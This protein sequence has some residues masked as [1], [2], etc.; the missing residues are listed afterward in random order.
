MNVAENEKKA[1]NHTLSLWPGSDYPLGATYD[2]IGT[3]FSIFSEVAQRVEL[4]L[5]D[6]SGGET[7]LAL[8]E[9]NGFVWHGYLSGLGPGQRYG[10]RVHGPWD[11]AYGHRCCPSKLLL[12]PYAKAIE[13]AV[14]W[15]DALF[16]AKGKNLD[17][18]PDPTDTAGVMPKCVVINPYF[19]WSKERRPNVP[20]HDTIIYEAHVKGFTF[21]H[22]DIPEAIRGTYAGLAH[23]AAIDYLSKLGITAVELMP[24]QQFVHSGIAGGRGLRNYWGYD[25]ISYLA[26]HNEYSSGGTDRPAGA[27]VQADGSA[28]ARGGHRGHSGRGLQPH[29][30]GQPSGADPVLQGNRQRLLLPAGKDPRHYEDYTGNGNSLN[31][32]HPQVLRMVMDSLRYWVTEMHVDGFRFDLAATLAG[33]CTR[34]TGFPR[35][36]QLSTRIR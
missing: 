13:G 12:D 10:Y 3:N 16:P 32:R 22:P 14:R 21:R 29:G 34:W 9:Q 1:A 19:D 15:G 18:P 28:A 27:G 24:V 5:F 4:C 26:P 33:N 6:D 36:S 30:R 25:P 31:M 23:P 8:P 35:S 2:G 7:R 20:F 17:A 11:P